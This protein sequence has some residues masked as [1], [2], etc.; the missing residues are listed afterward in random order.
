MTEKHI[1]EA[2]GVSTTGHEWDGI[3]ELNNPLPRWWLFVFWA[4]VLFSVIYWI[5]MPAWP[6]FPGMQGNTRGVWG[7]SD[8]T[9]VAADVARLKTERSELSGKLAT[10]DASSILKDHELSELALGLGE[11]A[12]GDNCATCHGTGGRGAKG[13]PQLADDVWLWG[14]T[15]REIEYTISL[16]VR[17][18][19][20]GARELDMPA[21]G[22]DQFL[23]P[24]QISDLVEY[25]SALSAR[26]ADRAAAERAAP[27]FAENCASCHGDDGR[28]GKKQGAP[29]LTDAEGL[30]GGDRE[31]IRRTIHGPRGGVMPTWSQRLDPATIRALAVYVHSLGGGQ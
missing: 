21:F 23:T 22:R 3:K 11:S 7:Q 24:S 29:N 2:T 18:G 13:Y 31:T 6:A 20:E 10:L 17:T 1:D 5:L 19:V 9:N 30:Y 27:V 25:V 26:E 14:G 16:G 15:L 8:R 4:T 12:F 28:G